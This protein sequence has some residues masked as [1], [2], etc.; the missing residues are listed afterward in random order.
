[1]GLSQ[2]LNSIMIEEG[3]NVKFQQALIRAVL[4]A[5]LTMV[6]TIIVWAIWS[7]IIVFADQSRSGELDTFWEIYRFAMY[8]SLPISMI[9]S[10]GFLLVS[11][12]YHFLRAD[13]SKRQEIA[14]SLTLAITSLLLWFPLP[15]GGPPL[16]ASFI[17]LPVLSSLWMLGSRRRPEQHQPVD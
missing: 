17:V 10:A 5:L 13:I 4:H 7:G 12:L 14:S 16:T 11:F 8:I 3:G 1:M 15:D 9:L 2:I 6:A